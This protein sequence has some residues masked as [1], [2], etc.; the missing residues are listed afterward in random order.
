MLTKT[1]IAGAIALSTAAGSAAALKPVGIELSA[2]P[3]ALGA[4]AQDGAFIKAAE[5]ADT[6]ITVSFKD[7]REFALTL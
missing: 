5:T 3:M 1:V 4:N 7:G 2:G 6:Q